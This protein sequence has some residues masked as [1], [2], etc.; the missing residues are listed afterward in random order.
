M[1]NTRTQRI[2]DTGNEERIWWHKKW[3]LEA[4]KFKQNN[5]FIQVTL[6]DLNSGEYGIILILYVT[7]ILMKN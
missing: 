3:A 6:K 1:Y 5:I 7:V 2:D 4:V